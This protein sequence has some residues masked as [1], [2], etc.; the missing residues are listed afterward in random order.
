VI[1]W[2]QLCAF[3]YMAGFSVTCLRLY[4]DINVDRQTWSKWFSGRHEP[5]VV[6]VVVMLAWWLMLFW[7]IRDW[8]SGEGDEED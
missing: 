1:T 5:G 8:L 7:E 4:H 6:V 3:M 2:W